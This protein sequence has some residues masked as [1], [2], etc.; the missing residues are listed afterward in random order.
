VET[1]VETRRFSNDVAELR[2]VSA[3]VRGRATEEHLADELSERL[4]LSVHE[5]VANIIRHGYD[6]GAIGSIAISLER[7]GDGIQVTLIDQGRPFDPRGHRQAPFPSTIEEA[8]VG[9][10]GITIIRS[11]AD[12]LDYRRDAAGNVFVLRFS[13]RAGHLLRS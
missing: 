2:A 5:A 11:S 12:A 1:I 4:D 13:P 8:P 3:W 6:E 9:G 10:L 7:V